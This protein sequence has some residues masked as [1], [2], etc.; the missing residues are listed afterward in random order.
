MNKS[1]K[2]SLFFHFFCYYSVTFVLYYKLFIMLPQ[3][4]KVQINIHCLLITCEKIYHKVCYWEASGSVACTV[5]T[6]TW[7]TAP[8]CFASAVL[9]HTSTS[10]TA[11]RQV[12]NTV[13]QVARKVQHDQS[14]RLL[15]R[16]S[17]L[18]VAKPHKVPK[19]Y[20][21]GTRRHQAHRCPH[22][23]GTGAPQFQTA[24]PGRRPGHWRP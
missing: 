16:T 8:K 24:Q 3:I 5:L 19:V 17:N 10:H 1:W 15:A 12:P 23:H 9:V 6:T 14:L 7:S 4:S 11:A 2:S 18:R 20:L 21:Q 13:L 22:P